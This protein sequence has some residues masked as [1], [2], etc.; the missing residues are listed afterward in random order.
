MFVPGDYNQAYY[1]IQDLKDAEVKTRG[2]IGHADIADRLN[3]MVSRKIDELPWFNFTDCERD[4]IN[5]F[6]G[7]RPHFK[8]AVGDR[9]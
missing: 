4:L 5:D 3:F 2:I 1:T 6:S 7:I 8:P 9:V